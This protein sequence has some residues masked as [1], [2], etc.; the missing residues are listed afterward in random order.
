MPK[1]DAEREAWCEETRQL[2]ADGRNEKSHCPLEGSQTVGSVSLTLER[3]GFDPAQ[4]YLYVR[5]TI[6][7][8]Y[9]PPEASF[10]VQHV[11]LNGTELEGWYEPGQYSASAAKVWVESYGTFTTF[12][13]W[14]SGTRGHFMQIVP[15]DLPDTF[16]IRLVWDVYDRD[17]E[18]NRV[19]IGTFDITATV[20]K[21]DIVPGG[22]W[23]N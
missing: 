14:E 11:H 23:D 5:Y 17:K 10:S 2:A 6:D 22:L 3:L 9:C 12:D 4:R 21:A 8:L 18:Y 20:H 15:K 13:N 7:G 16:E 1:D 19:F